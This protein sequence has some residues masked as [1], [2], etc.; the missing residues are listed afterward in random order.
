MSRIVIVIWKGMNSENYS[1]SGTTII[2]PSM[3]ILKQIPQ[4]PEKIKGQGR[5]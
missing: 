5:S 2:C 1:K 4:W 3:Q